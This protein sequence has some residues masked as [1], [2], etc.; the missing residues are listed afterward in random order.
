MK[1]KT[2]KEQPQAEVTSEEQGGEA[3]LGWDY[4]IL[5]TEG[6]RKS[7]Q[8]GKSEHKGVPIVAERGKKEFQEA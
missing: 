4:W 2:E 1:K 3:G 7:E 5:G 6:P 8:I